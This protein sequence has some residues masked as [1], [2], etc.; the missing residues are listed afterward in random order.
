M[1]LEMEII[2]ELEIIIMELEMKI[3]GVILGRKL[4]RKRCSRQ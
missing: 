2:M 1:E 4:T 3:S